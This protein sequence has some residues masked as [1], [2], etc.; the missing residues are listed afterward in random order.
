M[1][2]EISLTTGPPQE[3]DLGGA[4]TADLRT[5]VSEAWRE[6]SGALP[7]A[8]PQLPAAATIEVTLDPTATGTG[9]A[10]YRVGVRADAAAGAMTAFAVG[11]AE[12]P[13]GYRLGRTAVGDLVAL[14]WSPPGVVAEAGESFGL[15]L[16]VAD[17]G[18][19]AVI[20]TRTMRDVYG[21]P[22]PA[23]LTFFACDGEG[24]PVGFPAL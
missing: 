13:D 8:L 16:P 22:H 10:V 11:N 20:L 3:A 24:A 12:L 5:K 4:F 7:P 23:F 9:D 18:Q 2:S 1:P 14:G 15:T 17:C 21:A 6:F 19:L